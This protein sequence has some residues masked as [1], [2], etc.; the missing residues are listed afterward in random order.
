MMTFNCAAA[1]FMSACGWRVLLFVFLYEVGECVQ[2]K[3]ENERKTQNAAFAQF[4]SDAA[5]NVVLHGSYR[6]ND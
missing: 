1:V 2:K 6:F 3:R 4:G 5:L